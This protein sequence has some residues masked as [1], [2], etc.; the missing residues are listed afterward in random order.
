MV[1]YYTI[2]ILCQEIFNEKIKELILI[3]FLIISLQMSE[4]K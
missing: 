2:T 4:G 3:Y 1:P